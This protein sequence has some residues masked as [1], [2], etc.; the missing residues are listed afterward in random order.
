[1]AA[2]QEAARIIA[3]QELEKSMQEIDIELEEVPEVVVNEVMEEIV[4]VK[5]SIPS[6]T[7][8][9]NPMELIEAL[10]SMKLSSEIRDTVEKTTNNHHFSVKI[11]KIESTIIAPQSFKNG[12]T[13]IGKLADDNSVEIEL[14]FQPEANDS[15]SSF[16]MNHIV[17]IDAHI[18]NWN[19]GRK[20]AIF[21]VHSYEYK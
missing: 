11:E 1:M 17:E 13:I 18:A 20:R 3:E 5:N 2:E 6:T 8:L 19:I 21:S 10:N 9:N 4:E 15:V 14:L 12:K 16:Q 7:P